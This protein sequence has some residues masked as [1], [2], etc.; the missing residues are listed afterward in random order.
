MNGDLVILAAI[1]FGWYLYH[2]RTRPPEQFI[3]GTK[4]VLMPSR[5]TFSGAWK[6]DL[7]IPTNQWGG[8][9]YGWS[10]SSAGSYLP[11]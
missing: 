3:A 9:P 8:H 4:T 10:G 11:Q 7:P 6:K 5:S 1:G 2:N